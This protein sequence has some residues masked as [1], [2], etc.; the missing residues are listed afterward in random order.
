MHVDDVIVIPQQ[1]E[2]WERARHEVAL[3]RSHSGRLEYRLPN[4]ARVVQHVVLAAVREGGE[5]GAGSF[6]SI[7]RNITRE[8]EL[9][10]SVQL[11]RRLE[12]V[13]QLA[14]GLAHDFNNLLTVILGSAESIRSGRLRRTSKRSSKRAS[15]RP[16]SPPS[17]CRSAAPRRSA[18]R[19]ST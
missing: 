8:A 12:A 3:G 5:A 11:T 17:C 9:E 6:V 18:S 14:G 19:T 13:G 10:E 1:R 4:G 16:P 15:A 2:F 7:A